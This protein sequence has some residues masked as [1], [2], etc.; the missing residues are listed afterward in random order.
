MVHLTSH[1]SLGTVRPSIP[2]A[3]TKHPALLSPLAPPPPRPPGPPAAL[4]PPFSLISPLPHFPLHQTLAAT[5]NW[6][7]GWGFD[8]RK[9]I[10][11]PKRFLPA[12][13]D[14]GERGEQGSE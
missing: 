1:S 10:Y 12:V 6:P 13:S 9:N 7:P 14:W 2:K 11:A 5:Q 8:G 3:P 4:P